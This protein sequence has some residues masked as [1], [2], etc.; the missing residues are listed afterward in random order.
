MALCL[1]EVERCRPYVVAMLG[2]RYGWAQGGPG[3]VPDAL[4]A[5]SL[6]H[7]SEHYSWVTHYADRSV[8]E[9]E[10]LYAALFYPAL[11]SHAYI[12]LRDT[13]YSRTHEGVRQFATQSDNDY[14]AQRVRPAIAHAL[15]HVV[16]RCAKGGIAGER[17][18]RA[19]PVCY[20]GCFCRP[21]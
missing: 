21:R 10:L 15:A 18:A 2:E 19:R 1:R 8:T 9:L 20:A 7:A 6:Q 17:A 14:D 11:A 12:Y 16:A 4:L 5:K 3:S 13:A